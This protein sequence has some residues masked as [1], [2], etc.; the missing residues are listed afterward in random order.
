MIIGFLFLALW[1]VL[2]FPLDFTNQVIDGLVAVLISI[3]IVG[4][5][6]L[7]FRQTRKI[8]SR[9]VRK[10]FAIILVMM[11]VIYSVSSIVALS[12]AKANSPVWKDLQVCSS[13]NG[14]NVVIQMRE[15]SGSIYDYRERLILHQFADKAR[16]IINWDKRKMHGVWKITDVQTDSVYYENYDKR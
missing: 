14:Q 3:I 4:L 12:F 8:E 5:I 9:I 2:G 16:V 6:Y 1:L 15:T 11:T 7:L 10:G 13:Q